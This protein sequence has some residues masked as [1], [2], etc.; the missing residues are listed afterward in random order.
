MIEW[1][2]RH[3]HIVYF[4][5][6]YT[7]MWH[8][9]VNGGSSAKLFANAWHAELWIQHHLFLLLL[10]WKFSC[11]MSKSSPNRVTA[12][13]LKSVWW[14]CRDNH[15]RS[16]LMP[17]VSVVAFPVSK[18]MNWNSRGQTKNIHEWQFGTF[19]FFFSQICACGGWRIWKKIKR[20]ITTIKH[21]F[22]Y[23]LK[24]V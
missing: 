22:L 5:H 3:F 2:L 11:L 18:H 14:H 12:I 19:S 13:E 4:Q 16:M 7:L 23:L 20:H 24:N 6:I 17:W 10:L 21:V 9:N 15:H 8:G 1:F